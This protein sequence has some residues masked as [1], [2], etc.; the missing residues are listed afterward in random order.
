[1][2]QDTENWQMLNACAPCLYKLENE[3]KLH[4]LLLATMDDNQ[5]LKLVDSKF[6]GG[7]PLEDTRSGRTNIYIPTEDV[8]HFKNEPSLFPPFMDIA[9]TT[10]ARSNGF[11][12]T[13]KGSARRILKDVS[14]C[15]QSP[16]TLPQLPV[17]PHHSTAIKP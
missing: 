8:E 15:S 16:T 11:H 2:K 5:S 1:M 13:L 10:A 3:P 12:C 6:K 17:S 4:F 9:T 14:D 7:T